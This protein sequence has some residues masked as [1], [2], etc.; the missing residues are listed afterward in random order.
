ML[1]VSAIDIVHDSAE[2]AF[3]CFDQEVIVVAH[4]DV[5]VEEISVF[6]LGFFQVC[7]EFLIIGFGMK[8]FLTLIP[9]AGH[10]IKR[11]RIFNP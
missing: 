3:R 6:F 7:L 2:V 4:E 1:P 9:A 5:T 11:P 10:M 8:D